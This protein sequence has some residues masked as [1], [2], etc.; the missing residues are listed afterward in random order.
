MVVAAAAVVVA[1]G[2]VVMVVLLSLSLLLK[3][4]DSVAVV[5]VDNGLSSTYIANR[6]MMRHRCRQRGGCCR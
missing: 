4:A 3:R 5:G 6:R 1:T 2:M